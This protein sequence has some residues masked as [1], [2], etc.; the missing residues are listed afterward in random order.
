MKKNY[1]YIGIDGGKNG[2]I[3]VAYAGNLEIYKMPDTV[4]IAKLFKKWDPSETIIFLEKVSAFAGE[5]SEKRFG[6][7]KMLEQVKSIK[8]VLEL[9]GFTYIEIA[10]VTWQSRLNLR[11]KG[12]TKE[13]RKNLYWEYAKRYAHKNKVLKSTADAVCILACGIKLVNEK[14]PLVSTQN[15]KQTDLF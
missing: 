11:K 10:S 14:D 13:E 5:G 4:G 2:A 3:A 12:L 1:R 9:S 8:V 7:I 15:F 6:I